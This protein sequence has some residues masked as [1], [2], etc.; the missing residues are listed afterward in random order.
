MPES[1]FYEFEKQ[2]LSSGVS[3]RHIRRAVLEIREHL[4][5]IK[6]DA[7]G[8][9]MSSIEAARFARQ[10]IGDLQ[11]IATLIAEKRELR[12]WPYRYP[13]LARVFLPIAYAVL[14]PATPIFASV[15]RVPD[16][17]RWALCVTLGAVVTG[18]MFLLLQLSIAFN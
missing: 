14:L 1:E 12:A 7:L 16:I 18:G 8:D 5:D 11:L 4:D 3:P 10:Q 15:A 17:A 13:R 2:L 9:G 6:E